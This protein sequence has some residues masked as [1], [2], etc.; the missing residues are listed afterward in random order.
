MGLSLLSYYLIERPLW[1]CKWDWFA[2]FFDNFSILRRSCGY[3]HRDPVDRKTSTISWAEADAGGFQFLKRRK[4]PYSGKERAH[5]LSQEGGDSGHN[6]MWLVQGTHMP[7]IAYLAETCRQ[8][9]SCWLPEPDRP[10]PI[11]IVY[12]RDV[13]LPHAQRDDSPTLRFVWKRYHEPGD[14]IG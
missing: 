10:K 3:R 9:A 11:S 5:F 13:P 14:I 8:I 4:V 2:T 6:T 12:E 7:E 1:Y